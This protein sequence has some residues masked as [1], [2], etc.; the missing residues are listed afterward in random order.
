MESTK[1]LYLIHAGLLSKQLIIFKS[2][3]INVTTQEWSIK[4]IS[5]MAGE[6]QLKHKTLASLMHNGMM[7]REMDSLE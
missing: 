7:E 1:T 5:H 6:E 3:A 4:I 2:L